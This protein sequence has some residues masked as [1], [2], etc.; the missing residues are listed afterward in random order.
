MTKKK[1][2][3]SRSAAASRTGLERAEKRPAKDLKSPK[4][5]EKPSDAKP[6]TH[7]PSSAA[8]R[9]TIE[10]VVIAFVLAFLF[11]TF[12]AEA[13]VIPTGSMAPTLMGRHKDLECSNCGY[14]F[15][16]SASDEVDNSNGTL[17]DGNGSWVVGC[18]CPM[19]RF[20]MDLTNLRNPT[21]DVLDD[22]P[23]YTGDRILVDKFSY[24]F[25]DPDRWDVVVFKFPGGAETNYIKRL[26][27]LPGET[28]RIKH[29]DIYFKK[30]KDDFAIARK[31]APD[32]LVAMLLP[33]FD[34]RVMPKLIEQGWPSRWDGVQGPGGD[35]VGGWKTDDYL[36]F[37]T[38]PDVSG[39]TWFRYQH[40]V[41]SLEHWRIPSRHNP[42][43]EGLPGPKLGAKVEP[44]WI[45]NFCAYNSTGLLSQVEDLKRE[46]ETRLPSYPPSHRIHQE[47]L[48]VGDLA[49]ECTIEVESKK[50]EAMLELV[51]GGRS[52]QCRIDVSSGKATLT[53]SGF[54]S[55]RPTAQTDV[56]GPGQYELRFANCDDQLR[57]WVDGD[58]IEFDGTTTYD[59]GTLHKTEQDKSPVAVGSAGAKLR[60]SNLN[61]LRD[62]YFIADG[63]DS[64][65]SG[66]G[67]E[68][69]YAD[70]ELDE[71]Q[72][73]TLGDNS[74]RSKDARLWPDR[75]K[76]HWPYKYNSL[77]HYV[78][79]DLL[80]GKALFIYWPDTKYK[81][82]TPRFSIPYF[83]NFGDMELV[84]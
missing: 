63:S 19:C 70:F 52:M 81:I 62:T 33:V 35:A 8:I 68:K 71:D 14:E 41:P 28:I 50:G 66:G 5:E 29:G 4:G 82:P 18:T 54:D 40:R 73:F 7:V 27:G 58:E 13:F 67:P 30:G 9:E 23:S 17:K 49:V 69:P 59:L 22:Y 80:I 26:V 46:K 47:G 38:K 64:P 56:R 24:Q 78:R 20:P 83:P 57:L 6:K 44:Q 65:W 75:S 72:F 45:T 77:P 61:I 10:S 43:M 1:T 16:V 15:E 3:R 11:R 2:Q 60:V 48:W 34:N 51:E 32:K 21:R 42:P 79:R 53:I 76:G 84:R 36:I 37:A 55:F 74:A 12:E 25:A 39:E 31:E